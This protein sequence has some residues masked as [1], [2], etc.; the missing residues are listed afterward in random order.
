MYLG[1]GERFYGKQPVPVARHTGWPYIVV[2]SGRPQLVLAERT[3]TLQTGTLFVMHPDCASGW[4]DKAAGRSAVLAWIWKTPPNA[5]LSVPTNSMIQTQLDPSAIERLHELHLKCRK[6]VAAPDDFTPAALAALH[7]CLD[8]E[9]QRAFSQKAKRHDSRLQLELA[10]QWMRHNLHSDRPVEMLCAYLEL[11]P[12]TLHR[13]FQAG[14]NES[15]TKHFHRLRMESAL[16]LLQTTS[17]PVKEVA[18]IH[19]YKHP[20]D[21]TRAFKRYFNAIPKTVQKHEKLPRIR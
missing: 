7:A 2:V 20:N 18:F 9:V 6:E 8:V 1:W 21:F 11:S 15:P 16:K 19:G 3:A 4:A 17:L 12:R 10:I 5:A 14:T 13:F